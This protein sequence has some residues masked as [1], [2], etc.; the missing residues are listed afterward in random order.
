MNDKTIK[1]NLVI[2][3]VYWNRL[4]VIAAG[5]EI[6]RAAL[7]R[8]VLRGV[9]EAKDPS[10][11]LPH[12]AAALID[13]RPK[14]PAPSSVPAQEVRRP[15]DVDDSWVCMKCYGMWTYSLAACAECGTLAPARPP[16]APLGPTGKPIP[17]EEQARSGMEIGSDEFDVPMHWVD[18]EGRARSEYV[19][20]AESDL[21][22]SW[23]P[24]PEQG[25]VGNA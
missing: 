21:G 10:I 3:R 13:S 12:R 2:E 4:G 5:A 24:P 23:G 11:Y 19:A 20:C 7:I 15:V 22:I 9:C 8:L 14:A 1:R 6:S 25:P 18:W 16:P 17:S